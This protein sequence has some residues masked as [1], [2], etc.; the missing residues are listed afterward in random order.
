MLVGGISYQAISYVSEAKD[1]VPA[2]LLVLGC[3]QSEAPAMICLHQ[4]VEIGKAELVGRG[5]NPS[6]HYALE[7]ALWGYITLAPDCPGFGNY[8]CDPYS[9]GYVSTVMKGIWNH[10][11][12]VDLLHSLPAVD[13]VRIGCI[14]HSLGGHNSV[15]LAVFDTRV[16]AIISSCGF[17]SFRKYQGGDLSSWSH[18]VCMPRTASVYGKD[19][20]RMPFDFPE[21]V[22]A[23][24]PRPFFLNTPL[25]DGNFEV[26]GVR[27]CIEAAAPIY[28]LLGAPET[29]IAYLS[30]R[31]T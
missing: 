27:D 29:L 9:M 20:A 19:P 22:A 23:L 14:G 16:K 18:N 3:V 31:R 11:R 2:Y 1:R 17:N 5:G 10:L 6:L 30:R 24:A 25:R 28:E 13:G 7:L 21:V 12:A 4:T 15:F 8:R 26:S